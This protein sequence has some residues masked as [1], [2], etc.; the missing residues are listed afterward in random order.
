VSR[1]EPDATRIV[2]LWLEE[3][4]TTLP[5][6]VLDAVLDQLPATS[7]RRSSWLAR[8]SPVMNN[9]VRIALAAAAVVVVALIGYQFFVAPN[10]GVP[11]PSPSQMASPTPEATPSPAP[12]EAAVFPPNG[13]LEIGR[14]AMT[15]AGVPLTFE[16]T[17]DGWVS[18]GPYFLDKGHLDTPDSAGF[19]LWTGS[20]PD[21]TY[22]DPCAETPLEPPAGASAAELAAAVSTVPGTELVSGP[23]EVTIG[24]YPAQYVVITIPEDIGCAPEAFYLWYD[25]DP[26]QEIGRYASEL[27]STIQTWIIDVD[28]TLVWIDGETYVA[29]SPEAAQEVEQIVN[30]IQFE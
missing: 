21:N 20:A 6:H 12:S 8:R 30:S 7:Q 1:S 4:V 24:G 25:G 14:H 2:R 28:G 27:G 3:G 22:G 23:S 26:P 15:M 19:I 5:D 18:Q 29:S 17:T 13:P 16:V 11:G 10:V 9:T